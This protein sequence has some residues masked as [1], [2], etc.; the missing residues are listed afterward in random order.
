M[1]SL[2]EL[3]VSFAAAVLDGADTSM[4]P[5]IH[6]DG[7]EP[8]ARINIYRNN[9]HEGFLK[10]L[11][12]EFPVIQRLVG[13]DYFRR[14]A[15]EFQTEH[16]SRAGD[17]QGI[18]APFAG[19]LRARFAGTD[20]PYLPDVAALEWA[21]QLSLIAADDTP[22]DLTPLRA[23]PPER[24]DAS[25]FE[26]QPDCQ[27]VHSEFPIVRIWLANQDERDGTEV[28]DLRTG[29]D[30]VL[31]RRAGGAVE[32]HQLPAADFFFLQS[33]QQGRSLGDS[34]RIAEQVD[35][36]LDLARALRRLAGLGVFAAVHPTSPHHRTGA[37]P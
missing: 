2:R 32:L 4:T 24:L 16:P 5:W 19:F 23:L 17:L 10:A 18:G 14:L 28:I 1:L 12:L 22:L 20:Y 29:A 34:L 37:V 9:A 3:Q 15:R 7:L 11:A 27:L 31:L 30:F 13:E 8:G 6:P 33:L 21:Y 36:E 25:C 35:P 26:L